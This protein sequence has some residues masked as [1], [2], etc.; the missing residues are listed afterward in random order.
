[1]P[2]LFA[3]GAVAAF[4]VAVALVQLLL[5]FL[6]FPSYGPGEVVGLQLL[7]QLGRALTVGIGVFLVFWL[8][9]P[10]ADSP[11]IRR[12]IGGGVVAAV[13]AAVLVAVSDVLMAL[14]VDREASGS[15]YDLVPLN[16]DPGYLVTDAISTTLYLLPLTVLAAVLVREWLRS[17]A[18]V[19]ASKEP[20]ST[21]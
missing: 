16:L 7:S 5:N 20:V 18:A 21:V 3:A 10:I 11:T 14:V 17:R 13:G 19:D 1:L 12:V 15:L 2:A 9:V 6:T 4:L 8:V